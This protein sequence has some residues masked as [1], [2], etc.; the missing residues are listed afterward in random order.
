MFR[1]FAK[2]AYFFSFFLGS[3]FLTF[4]IQYLFNVVV[5]PF[6]TML[7]PPWWTL[8]SGGVMSTAK[9]WWVFNGL[10]FFLF[11]SII[12]ASC[13][14]YVII[15]KKNLFFLFIINV[16]FNHITKLSEFIELSQVN[17]R[18]LRFFLFSLNISVAWIIF[19]Y[20]RKL[21]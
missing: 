2:F 6:A 18:A 3:C 12:L 21:D 11:P 20:V 19:F 7:E 1:W 10:F 4:I 17:D 16:F 13:F 15:V 8:S 5:R 9:R 14:L